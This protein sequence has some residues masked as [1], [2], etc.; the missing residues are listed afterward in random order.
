MRYYCF[1]GKTSTDFICTTNNLR[2]SCSSV[3]D[4]SS[5]FF[6]L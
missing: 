5:L 1:T 4:C 2:N 3:N 6:I